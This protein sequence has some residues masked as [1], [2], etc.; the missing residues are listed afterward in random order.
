MNKNIYEILIRAN[1]LNKRILL[2]AITQLK[3]DKVIKFKDKR[4]KNIARHIQLNKEH[5]SYIR[6]L[7]K[8]SLSHK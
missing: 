4:Y 7:Y 3:N 8:S 6:N 2:S 1:D 5:R